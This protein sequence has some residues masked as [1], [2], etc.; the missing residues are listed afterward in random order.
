MKWR[1]IRKAVDVQEATAD[2]A[3]APWTCGNNCPLLKRGELPG[4]EDPSAQPDFENMS[5]KEL[6][7]LTA[8]LRQV[9][10]KRK[11]GYKQELAD[12]PRLQ[13]DVKLRLRRFCTN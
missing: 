2:P 9:E 4:S 8:T 10:L 6:R 11:K 13:F 3:L 7:E 1:M 5:T 12:H